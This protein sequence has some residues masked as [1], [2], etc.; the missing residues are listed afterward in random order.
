VNA[1][2]VAA[3]LGLALAITLVANLLLLDVASGPHDP[4]GRLSPRAALIQ[5]PRRP[6]TP[7]AGTSP[8][9]RP[10]ARPGH[11]DER[12]AGSLQDD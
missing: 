4:V 6:A 10:P 1:V 7:R 5:L 2:R 11:S 9:P 8:A 12:R 3:L